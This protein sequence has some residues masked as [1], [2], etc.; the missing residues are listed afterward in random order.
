MAVTVLTGGD[1]RHDGGAGGGERR[2]SRPPV[3]SVPA[4]VTRGW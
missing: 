1:D 2:D 3:L 4:P